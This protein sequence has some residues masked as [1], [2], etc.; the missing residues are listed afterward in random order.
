MAA[1]TDSYTHLRLVTIKV[2]ETDALAY[3]SHYSAS[4]GYLLPEQNGVQSMLK[5]QEM[6]ISHTIENVCHPCIIYR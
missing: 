2:N 5:W 3:T 4:R 1:L 6:A